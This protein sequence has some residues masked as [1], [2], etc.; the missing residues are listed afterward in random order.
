MIKRLLPIRRFHRHVQ[1]AEVA[2][3]W[4]Q[5]DYLDHLELLGA[6]PHALSNFG[7]LFFIYDRARMAAP[8]N[9]IADLIDG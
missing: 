8:L 1:K 7:L 2:A 6:K 4:H 3:G 9:H 5:I